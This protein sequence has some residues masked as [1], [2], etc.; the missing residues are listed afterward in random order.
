MIGDAISLMEKGLDLLFPDKTEANAQKARLAEMALNGEFQG[1]QN[2]F[3]ARIAQIKVNEKEAEHPDIFVS[4]WRPFLGWVCAGGFAWTYVIRDF[5][6]LFAKLTGA[7]IDVATLPQPN[8]FE[9][10]PL[11]FGM[12]GLSYN[13]SDE[14]KS[15][16]AR[17]KL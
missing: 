2:D 17:N 7:E 16:V 13:R 3:D 10:M 11:L 6:I 9:L 15:G 4:G 5:I 12:L 14:K 8:I 1:V